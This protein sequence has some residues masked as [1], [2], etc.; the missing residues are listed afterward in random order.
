MGLSFR[1]S[2]KILP[3][4]RVNFS[5]SGASISIG[6]CGIR[7][8]FSKR[9]FRTSIGIPG[10]GISYIRQYSAKSAS[11]DSIPLAQTVT[12]STRGLRYWIK[13]L[14][15]GYV[16]IIALLV[17]G[18]TS[19]RSIAPPRPTVVPNSKNSV[20]S[21]LSPIGVAVC[22]RHPGQIFPIGARISVEEVTRRIE[23]NC[24]TSTRARVDMVDL[25]YKSLTFRVEFR[26]IPGNSPEYLQVRS[27]VG[28]VQ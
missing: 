28:L 27:V 17:I 8:N 10:S 2:V 9:G 23:M 21:Q 3:G 1:K 6:G 13:W 12:R 15:I 24:K 16:L 26:K 11:S 22:V 20:S 14:L 4:L 7:A 19:Q 5:K 25:A 18:E